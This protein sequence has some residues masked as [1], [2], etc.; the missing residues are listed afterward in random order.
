MNEVKCTLNQVAEVIPTLLQAN[1]VPFLHSSPAL[2]K[3]SVAKQ[4]AEKLNLKVI[5]LRLTECDSSD[6]NGLPFFKDGKAHFM[7]F[8]TFP[9]QDTPIPD[10]YKGWLLLLDEFNSALPSVQAS[11]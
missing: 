8:D 3:S 11:A 10:G 1:V 6:L 5:D 9:T 4:V 7:P 2:G